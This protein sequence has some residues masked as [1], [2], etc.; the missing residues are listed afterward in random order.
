MVKNRTVVTAVF[1]TGILCTA[2][3]C[4]SVKPVSETLE[5]I[6]V[7]ATTGVTTTMP[8]EAETIQTTITTQVIAEQVTSAY[9]CTT[10]EPDVM[11]VDTLL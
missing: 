10:A 9:T 7:T 4:N 5:T 11:L 8:D 6:P 1:L 3:G 2:N